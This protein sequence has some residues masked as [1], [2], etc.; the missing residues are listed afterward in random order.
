MRLLTESPPT[1]LHLH[2]SILHHLLLSLLSCLGQVLLTFYNRC[3]YFLIFFDRSGDNVEESWKI[4]VVMQSCN[5]LARLSRASRV[6]MRH[7]VPPHQVP[8]ELS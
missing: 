2:A 4:H 8:S 5:L 7:L 1:Y 6:Q 3:C